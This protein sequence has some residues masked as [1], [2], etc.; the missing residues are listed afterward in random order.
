MGEGRSFLGEVAI[1][2]RL[3]GVPMA[4]NDGLACVAGDRHAFESFSPRIRRPSLIGL[5][6]TE[7]TDC[8]EVEFIMEPKDSA[9]VVSRGELRG[10]EGRGSRIREYC[11]GV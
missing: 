8:T 9:Q 1:D 6:C 4:G 5:N 11:G 3:T 2:I 7:C 10:T